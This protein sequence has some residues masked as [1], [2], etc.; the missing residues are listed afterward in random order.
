MIKTGL[1]VIGEETERNIENGQTPPI[2]PNIEEIKLTDKRSSESALKSKTESLKE[3][4]VEFSRRTNVDCYSKIFEY[5]SIFI[6]LIWIVILVTSLGFT[7]YLLVSNVNNYLNY[8]VTTKIGSYYELPTEFPAVTFCNS[9]AFTTF[10]AQ[11]LFWQ[12]IND[13]GWEIAYN[14]IFMRTSSPSYG[15]DDRKQ[16]GLSIDQISCIYNN[17]DCKNDLHWYWSYDY[18]NCFQFNTGLNS[19]GNFIDKTQVNVEGPL[20][21]LHIYINPFKNYNYYTG[22]NDFGV[23]VFVH[24]SSLKPTSSDIVYLQPGQSSY[25]QVKRT[26]VDNYPTPYTSCTDLSSYSSPLYDYITKSL[27]K[28]Y[29]Q[30]DCFELCIQQLIV[31][32]CNCSHSGFNNPNVNPKVEPCLT[33][34]D[35]YCFSSII[36]QFDPMAC[37]SSSCPLECKSVEYDL[38]ASSLT[39]PT[40]S[41]Y[42]SECNPNH[43]IPECIANPNMTYDDYRT[44]YVNFHVYYS[45]LAY[46]EVSVKPAMTIFDLIGNIGGSMSLIVSISFFTV[47]EIGELL[48]LMMHAIIFKNTNR[49]SG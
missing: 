11:F 21:G 6:K 16:L 23:V 35:F 2:D 44:L 8:D 7:S 42:Y 19:T 48:I 41:L 26:Y 36:F 37:A 24:N 30:R 31:N 27:N 18:G 12:Y 10:Q 38:Y 47:F 39:F 9:N 46:S 32:T 15:D 3:I 17:M 5:N 34:H 22:T 28:T 29:R 20:R 25:I 4:F 1:Y 45:S 33:I 43:N 40:T 13:W 14:M 49:V